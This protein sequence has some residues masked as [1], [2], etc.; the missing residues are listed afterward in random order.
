M[1]SQAENKAITS[2]LRGHTYIG[3]YRD[4]KDPSSWL[5]ADGSRATYTNWDKGEP[6]YK[7]PNYEDCVAI[8]KSGYWHDWPCKT[9]K[10]YYVCETKG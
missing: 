10:N 1:K 5:W 2:R 4:P 8:H 9:A 7:Q 3:L 6:G